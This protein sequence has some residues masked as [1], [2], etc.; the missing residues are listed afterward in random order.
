LPRG[1]DTTVLQA[2]FKDQMWAQGGLGLL[3][4]F[5][6]N[7][8]WMIVDVSTWQRIASVCQGPAA[9][10]EIRKGT[11]RVMIESPA[12]WFLGAVLGWSIQAGGFLPSHNAY[13]AISDLSLALSKGIKEIPLFSS[14]AYPIWVAG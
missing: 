14:V 3:S 5:V 1:A 4:L 13:S 6:A 9:A 11:L 7:F 8:F 2:P 12:T 10:Q